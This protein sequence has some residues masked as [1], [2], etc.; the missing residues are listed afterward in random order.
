VNPISLLLKL[1]IHLVSSQL[2]TVRIFRKRKLRL[3]KH[4]LHA[5]LARF[6]LGIDLVHILNPNSMRNHLQRIQLSRFQPVHQIVPVHVNGCLAVSD[7]FD[8]ALHER[9]N[10]EVVRLLRC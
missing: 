6:K 2:R 5:I 7:E 1:S 3:Y 8:A 4:F 9:A 10:V